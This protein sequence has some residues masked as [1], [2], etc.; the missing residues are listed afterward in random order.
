MVVVWE[1]LKEP[2][3]YLGQ[4]SVYIAILFFLV[5]I[6][7]FLISLLAWKKKPSKKLLIVSVAFGLFFIKSILVVLDY[8]FSPGYFMNYAIQG[9]FDLI[10][11]TIL[12]VSLLKK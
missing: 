12:F 8:F 10:I 2:I 1:F 6:V 4:F 3:S 11:L 7:L 5:A 9:F